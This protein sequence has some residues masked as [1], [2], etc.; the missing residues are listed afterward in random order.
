MNWSDKPAMNMLRERLASLL[1]EAQTKE[2]TPAEQAEL[3]I[4]AA[5]QGLATGQKDTVS[6]RQQCRELMARAM[7]R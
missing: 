7:Q 2:V 1:K 3:L 6:I 5:V 4:D